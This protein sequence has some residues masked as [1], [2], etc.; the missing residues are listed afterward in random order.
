MITVETKGLD[1]L[2]RKLSKIPA[3]LRHKLRGAV[4]DAGHLVEAEAKQVQIRDGGYVRQ[5]IGGKSW[6]LAIPR[7]VADKVT[8]RTGRLRRSIA[9]V[10][11]FR[12][13]K[14]E[15]HVGTAV[16]YGR[17]LEEGAPAAT[18][19]PRLIP[20]AA[21]TGDSSAK[22][23]RWVAHRGKIRARHW[24]LKSLKAQERKAFDTINEAIEGALQ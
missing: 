5:R 24:L 17:I 13:D 16:G 23:F 18:F 10:P 3:A 9:T 8:A 14:M 19:S 7:P 6:R 15:A 1:E 11:D 22:G 20:L 12:G 2:N 4:L 21:I